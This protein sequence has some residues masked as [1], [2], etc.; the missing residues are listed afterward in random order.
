MIRVTDKGFTSSNLNFRAVDT[1]AS[2]KFNFEQQKVYNNIKILLQTPN[3]EFGQESA[4]NYYKHNYNM[5]FLVLPADKQS[6]K[7]T[8]YKTYFYNFRISNSREKI[9][10]YSINDTNDDTILQDIE[11]RLDKNK[12]TKSVVQAIIWLLIGTLTIGTAL[13]KRFHSSN[14]RTA[15]ENAD[16]LIKKS[17]TVMSGAADFLKAIKK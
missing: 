3:D 16:T 2:A 5:D 17:D 6:D 11:L 8:L 9:G 14:I 10:T 1:T 15:V 12:K 7:V 4:E 13:S